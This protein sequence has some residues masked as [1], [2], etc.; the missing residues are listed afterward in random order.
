[1]ASRTSPA[2]YWAGWAAALPLL[3]KRF[4]P[5]TLQWGAAEDPPPAIAAFR[6]ADAAL[7]DEGAL[8]PS[9]A[10][11][12]ENTV[13]PPDEEEASPEAGEFRHGWQFYCGNVR[14]KHAL[15]QFNRNVDSSVRRQMWSQ[16]GPGAA[17]F[18]TA[19]P[20]E[21]RRLLPADFLTVMRRRL[22]LVGCWRVMPRSTPV[23][24]P[25]S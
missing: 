16:A 11:L 13:R 12:S 22:C 24:R 25:R 9:W 19:K 21:P 5:L 17:A 14:E 4:R 15:E 6:E 7:R 8:L 18:L 1:M 3:H 23:A 10:E 20:D 2:A